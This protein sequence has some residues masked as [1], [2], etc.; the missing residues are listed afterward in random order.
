MDR[1]ALPPRLDQPVGPQPHQL[2]RHRYLLDPE[3][4]AQLGDRFLSIDK[5]AQ[6][7]QP[8]R[9]R[10]APHQLGGGFRR[11]DHFFY[12]HDLEFIIFEC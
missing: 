4:L 2:L 8:L 5:S 7:E 3:L 10:Q 12:I 1:G 11:R 6:H 9:M